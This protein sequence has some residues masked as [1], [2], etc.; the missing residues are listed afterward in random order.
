MMI[1][2]FPG[3]VLFIRGTGEHYLFFKS[4]IH[5]LLAHAMHHCLARFYYLSNRKWFR[6]DPDNAKPPFAGS[7]LY[8]RV[9][10]SYGVIR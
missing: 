8:T 10:L 1:A 4:H 6:E 3:A 9:L 7:S 5:V 2:G